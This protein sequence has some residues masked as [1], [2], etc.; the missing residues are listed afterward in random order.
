VADL[1]EQLAQPSDRRILL[2][3]LDGLSGVP[4]NGKTE[5][6]TAW[7]PNMNRL[8]AQSSLG[9]MQPAGI[10]ITPGSGPAHL[11]LFGYDPL[12]YQV[13]RGV[14]EALGIGFD[15]RPG[16]VCFRANF[17]TLDRAGKVADRRA[18]RIP[19]A[20]STPLCA[21]LQAAIPRTDDVEVFIRP[22]AEHRFVIVLRG[23][24]LDDCVTESD[25]LHD[26]AEPLPVQAREPAG[27]KTARLAR[28][29][30]DR[31]REEL[32]AEPVA[33]FVLLRGPARLPVMPTMQ[34]RYKLNPACVAAY[35]MYRGLAS[36]VG[37]KVLDAG[38]TWASELEAVRAH[39]D[40][41]DFFFLHFK[42]TDKAGE[43]GDFEG[44][45]EIIER[46]DE[47]VVPELEELRF[48]VLCITGD[49]ATPAVLG[50]HSWHPVPVLVKSP[51]CWPQGGALEFGERACGRGILSTRPSRE[52]MP[53]LLAHGLK[54]KKF[55]A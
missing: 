46:F 36:L 55:G 2:V 29:L 49:H 41:H 39:H 54:L 52:L 21:R 1:I 9:L 35:P 50:G 44:K 4:R 43:N 10:G 3:V 14:L 17:A 34:Q 19:N 6:E 32:K 5:L 28:A 8:A 23:P 38:Q 37:M 7:I 26:G 22:G 15:V 51:Y 13:G 33:N 47:E 48:D 27:D 42:E 40:E 31:C 30:V 16:D 11:A 12:Q 18:G 53:L 25:P 20:A 24:G 45:V